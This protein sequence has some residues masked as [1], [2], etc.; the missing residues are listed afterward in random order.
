MIRKRFLTLVEV[1][2][3]LSVLLVIMSVLLA[4]LAGVNRVAV[5]EG[6]RTAVYQQQQQLFQVLSRDLEGLHVSSDSGAQVSCSFREVSG[7]WLA[8]FVSTSGL[9]TDLGGTDTS[10]LV[11][12]G[13]YLQDS[14]VYRAYN[15][16][17]DPTRWDFLGTSSVDA[18]MGADTTAVQST[19]LIA[20]GVTDLS[21]EAYDQT[22]TTPL[23]GDLTTLPSFIVITATV[24]YDPALERADGDVSQVSTKEAGNTAQTF[25]KRIYY[26]K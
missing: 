4:L 24:L 5:A 6:G 19:A 25:S 8:R 9:G 16:S 1:L 17:S 11:E 10:R 2:V 3:A 23:L 12:V 21:I 7:S 15:T 14:N 20:E 26:S 22:G 18:W 13:Y